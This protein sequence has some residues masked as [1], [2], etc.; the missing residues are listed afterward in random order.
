MKFDSALM[1]RLQAA[2]QDLMKDGPMA[3]TA[4]IQRALAGDAAPETDATDNGIH[5]APGDG[6]TYTAPGAGARMKD[7]NA[8]P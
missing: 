1:A 5:A 2:T 6:T 8:P 3:A 7:L 4:A